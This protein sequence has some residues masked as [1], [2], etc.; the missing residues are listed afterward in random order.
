MSSTPGI[1]M[2]CPLFRTLTEL[3]FVLKA[4]QTR[5]EVLINGTPV[6]DWSQCMGLGEQLLCYSMLSNLIKN[7][8]EGAGEQG[9]VVIGKSYESQENKAGAWT[10]YAFYR[11]ISKLGAG[12]EV[13]K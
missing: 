12:I 6:Q 11:G 9:Q 3:G 8:E 10:R 2:C 13:R 5:T 7:V 1:L 4:N